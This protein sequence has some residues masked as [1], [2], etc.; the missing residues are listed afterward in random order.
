MPYSAD[1]A[2]SGT[3]TMTA[4][5]DSAESSIILTPVSMEEKS[6]QNGTNG[7]LL[8]NTN[9]MNMAATR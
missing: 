5:S 3:A 1:P 9:L 4:S 2:V 8:S 6:V 7:P